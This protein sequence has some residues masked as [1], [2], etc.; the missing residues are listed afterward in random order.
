MLDLFADLEITLNNQQFKVQAAGD[1]IT[2]TFP[3]A[4]AGLGFLRTIIKDPSWAASLRTWDRYLCNM[5]RTLFVRA[6]R[7]H[8]ALLGMKANP[9]LLTVLLGINSIRQIFRR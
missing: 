4:R 7:L 1:N 9:D 6:G 2:L 8:F 5:Y 3:S